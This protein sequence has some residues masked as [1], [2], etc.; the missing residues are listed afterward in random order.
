VHGFGCVGHERLWKESKALTEILLLVVFSF[1]LV[2]HSYISLLLPLEMAAEAAF[3]R[4]GFI[5]VA[6]NM[7]LMAYGAMLSYLMIVKDLYGT[8]LHVAMDD[9]PMKR[10][11]LFI[12]SVCIILPVSCQRVSLYDF[13]CDG[14]SLNVGRIRSIHHTHFVDFDINFAWGGKRHLLTITGYGRF[15]QNICR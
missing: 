7:F 6:A 4:A 5:F 3:G 14:M 8:I 12:V 2:T 9:Y 15:G 11:I 1:F 13:F 10:A